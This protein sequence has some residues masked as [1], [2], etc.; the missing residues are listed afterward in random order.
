MNLVHADLPGASVTEARNLP[1]TEF[2]AGT[3]LDGGRTRLEGYAS[4]EAISQLEALGATVEV[5]KSATDEEADFE[6]LLASIDK[7]EPPIA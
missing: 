1:G 2:F 4:D 3:P 6:Q 5:L 7:P